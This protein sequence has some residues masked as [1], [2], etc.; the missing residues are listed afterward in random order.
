LR[1]D[2]DTTYRRFLIAAAFSSSSIAFVFF[3]LLNWLRYQTYL[4][5]Y[6]IFWRAGAGWPLY[7]D[8][9]HLAFA[10]P[11]TSLILLTPFG[12]IPFWWSVAIWT[13]TGMSLLWLAGRRLVGPHDAAVGMLTAACLWLALAGQ[14]SGYIIALVVAGIVARRPWVKAACFAAAG[15][16]KPQ[17]LIAL[18]IALVAEKSF[19]TIAWGAIFAL[20]LVGFS[21]YVWGFQLWLQWVHSL[22]A[23]RALLAERAVDIA[24]VGLTGFALKIGLPGW[25]YIA[26]IPVGCLAVWRTF[27]RPDS[28]HVERYAALTC[29]G[30]LLSSYTLGYDLAALSIVSVAFLLDKER[31][32]N[33]WRASAMIVSYVLTAPGILLMAYCLAREEITPPESANSAGRRGTGG[34]SRPEAG[35]DRRR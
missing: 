19:K 35:R 4:G 9:H 23:F 18:P 26:G 16:I 24:D 2:H 32:K 6:L 30:V 25:V 7:R 34:A 8:L 13:A 27:S 1:P 15:V 31:S 5:D 17:T 29:G 10:Y 20:L 11:P 28:T 22:G 21:I 33:M 12:L 3:M 14:I